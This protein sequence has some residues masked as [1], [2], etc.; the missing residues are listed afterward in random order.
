MGAE[1]AARILTDRVADP[2]RRWTPQPGDEGKTP[3]QI[4]D[5]IVAATPHADVHEGDFPR[6]KGSAREVDFG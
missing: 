3:M 1:Q 6:L 5:E 2:P 4:L